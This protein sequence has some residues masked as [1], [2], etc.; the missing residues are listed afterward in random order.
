MVDFDSFA[1]H[2]L[3]W[4]PNILSFEDTATIQRSKSKTWNPKLF[5]MF[6]PPS[7]LH[8]HCNVIGLLLYP[9]ICRIG[10][11]LCR[12]GHSDIIIYIIRCE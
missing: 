7:T 2:F 3:V 9:G 5:L 1:C 4:L 10:R 12:Q 11:M 6:I 8:Q